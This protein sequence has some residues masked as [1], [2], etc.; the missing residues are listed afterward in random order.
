MCRYIYLYTHINIYL[1]PL[2]NNLCT[3]YICCGAT[4]VNLLQYLTMRE[5]GTVC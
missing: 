2:E 1:E 5:G 4:D 3:V